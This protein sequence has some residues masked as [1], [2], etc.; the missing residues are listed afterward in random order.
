[1]MTVSVPSWW[2]FGPVAG[3]ITT[4]EWLVAFPVALPLVRFVAES[5]E[6]V[7]EGTSTVFDATITNLG[8]LQRFMFHPHNDGYHTV[9]HL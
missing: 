2:W 3:L 8:F 9:H 7:Y 6:H 4:A 5:S 1:M